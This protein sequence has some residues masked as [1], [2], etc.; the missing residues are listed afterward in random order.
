M[1]SHKIK[2]PNDSK[3]KILCESSDLNFERSFMVI[4]YEQIF[5]CF[6]TLDFFNFYFKYANKIFIFLYLQQ[7]FK[8]KLFFPVI[9]CELGQ[10]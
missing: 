6:F 9:D 4:S 5:F 3:Y 8:L 10:F 7:I 2:R 1:Q